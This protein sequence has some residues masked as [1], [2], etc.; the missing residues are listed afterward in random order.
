M[1]H[2]V[3]LR[4]VTPVA[5]THFFS[6]NSLTIPSRP[7]G[8]IRGNVGLGSKAL[9]QYAC[10]RFVV[11][12]ERSMPTQFASSSFSTQSFRSGRTVRRVPGLT[13]GQSFEIEVAP[14][15]TG[16]VIRIP[17]IDAATRASRRSAVEIVARKHIAARTGI[18]IGYIAVYV[19]D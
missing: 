17:E 8:L 7:A 18:P 19:R 10:A 15:V 2:H 14:D 5:L 16:W 9:W 1:G 13:I 3:L 6:D 4:N 11:A 12:Q